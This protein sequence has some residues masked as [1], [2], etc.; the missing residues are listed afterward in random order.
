MGCPVEL[1]FAVVLNEGAGRPGQFNLLQ[2]RPM[3]VAGDPYDLLV[4]DEEKARALCYAT[5][6]LGNGPLR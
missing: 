1:E 5:H 4:T 6:A 2:L 3:P